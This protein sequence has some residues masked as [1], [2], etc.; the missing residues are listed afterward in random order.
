MLP[1]H[2]ASEIREDLG[3]MVTGQFKKIYM[4]RHENVSIL[5]ADIVGFTAISSTCPAPELVRI[6]NELFARFDKLSDKYHQLRIK[7]LGDCYY[8]ISGAPQ[9][10]SDHAVLCV[11]MGLSMVDAIQCVREETKSPVDM[12]VGIHTGGLLAGVMG[13]KQWQ[14]DVYSKDVEL[15]NKMESGGVPGKVHISEKTYSFLGGEF[16]VID[17]DGASREEAIRLAGIKTYLVTKVLK[18]YPEG[19]LDEIPH[20]LSSNL[21]SPRHSIKSCEPTSAIHHSKSMSIP[22]PDTTHLHQAESGVYDSDPIIGPG[23]EIIN[24]EEYNK[25]LLH[26]LLNRESGRNVRKNSNNFTLGFSDGNYEHQWK[27]IKDITSCISLLGLPLSCITFSLVFLLIGPFK[28]VIFATQLLN[29]S[30]LLLI[31]ITVSSIALK[32]SLVPCDPLLSIPACLKTSDLVQSKTL[33]RLLILLFMVTLWIITHITTAYFCPQTISIYQSFD[34]GM[35]MDANMNQSMPNSLFLSSSQLQH[36]IRHHHHQA[37]SFAT[38]PFSDSSLSDSSFSDSSLFISSVKPRRSADPSSEYYYHKDTATSD[39]RSTCDHASYLT[40]FTILG[41]IS[42]TVITRVSFIFKKLIIVCLMVSQVLLNL[43]RLHSSLDHFDQVWYQHREGSRITN[44]F[45]DSIVDGSSKTSS[46]YNSFDDTSG[47]NERNGNGNN[48]TS[49][50]YLIAHSH[51]LNIMIIT[52]A[53]VLSVLNRQFEL[54]SRRLFLWQK[55]VEEQKEQVSDIRRKNEAL[56]YNILPPHVAIHFLGRRNLKDEELYSMSYES[57]GV[58][59]AAMPNFSDFYTEES[60]N[61]QGLECLRFLNEVISD[62]DA[63]LEQERFKD[64]IKI[65]TIGSTYMAAS[66]LNVEEDDHHD[67]SRT[68]DSDHHDHSRTTD[69]DHHDHSRTMD[70]NRHLNKWRHMV[71]LT[72]FALS[73]KDTLNNINKESFNNFV[74]RIGINCGPITAGVIGA[75][76]PHYD[77]WGNTVNVA[78]RMESTGKAGSI[79]VTVFFLSCGCFDS[80]F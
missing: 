26:E 37:S 40:Y 63:L 12:R 57:V 2:V 36:Q 7:I 6:L 76:K 16:E 72:E 58:L 56:V 68:T 78:S 35:M 13:Q 38:S 65:K 53:I 3:S 48:D 79:Q 47:G 51:L 17:G 28:L 69:S 4:S 66:G 20:R 14:F 55:R 25:R 5:F 19:T 75:R 77:M 27:Y 29:N 32:T 80:E 45:I 24:I 21:P 67:H 64:V 50:F 30:I 8:C 60:V 54:M 62:Y 11:H 23:G 18:E 22:G 34:P 15:A 41:M 52:S 42:V 74:L 44:S 9:E 71:Q 70:S 49:G 1:K 33:I 10:R 73:L 61:N 46:S 43:L 31:S 59:F 39:D